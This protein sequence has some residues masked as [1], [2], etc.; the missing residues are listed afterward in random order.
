MSQH[1]PEG[2][3]LSSY[4]LDITLVVSNRPEETSAAQ[5]GRIALPVYYNF[6]IGK[7]VEHF[8]IVILTA[9]FSAG[10]SWSQKVP[11]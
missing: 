11:E 10:I 2:D 3:R 7:R 4:L 1:K 9:V 5:R 8:S 6:H